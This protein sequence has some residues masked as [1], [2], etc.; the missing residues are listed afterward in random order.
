MSGDGHD[1]EAH[2]YQNGAVGDLAA[3]A[4]L[5]AG[6]HPDRA[7]FGASGYLEWLYQDNPCGIA[8]QQSVDRRGERTAH[9]ALIPQQ[10]ARGDDVRAFCAG[11]NAVTRAGSG[12]VHFIALLRRAMR[13]M[14][15]ERGVVAGFGVTNES[16]TELTVT[17]TGIG[18]LG[19]LPILVRPCLPEG[20]GI[21]SHRV[22]EA[23]LAGDELDALVASIVP[24]S[25]GGWTQAWSAEILRWRLSNPAAD[26]RV[27][28]HR[29]AIAVTTRTV[30]R[31]VPVTVV[32]KLFARTPH[33]DPRAA[34]HLA[35]AACRQD[36]SPAAVYVG[37]N[38]RVPFRGMRV[39][40]RMAPSPLN[41][42]FF[43]AD[44]AKA[45]VGLESAP[46]A[47]EDVTLACFELL[48]FDAL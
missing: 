40:R 46:P 23:W 11:V 19:S 30:H 17:R 29:D 21:A 3:T 45:V 7:C 1:P 42:L 14:L 4:A 9:F 6:Q 22:T 44:Q 8:I 26:Y 32:L 34:S 13:Q 5:L 28:V 41:L 31:H 36:R 15:E 33:P 25:D 16:S 43:R 37:F 10:W 24:A 47:V 39:P 38:D 18:H 48:D 27:H 12:R 35:S 2:E 20:R